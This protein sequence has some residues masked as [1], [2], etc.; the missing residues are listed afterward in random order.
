M[1][2]ERRR[3]TQ[4]GPMVRDPAIALPGI[5]IPAAL[6][7]GALLKHLDGVDCRPRDLALYD[8]VEAPATYSLD[9]EVQALSDFAD[10]SG[11]ER[12]HLLGH[13]AGAAVAL[14]FTAVYPGRVV[15]LAL[16][17]P[18]SDFSP[19]DRDYLETA[20]PFMALPARDRVVDYLLGVAVPASSASSQPQVPE[21]LGRRPAA[22]EAFAKALMGH[23]VGEDDWQRF[24]GPV[25]YTYGSLSPPRWELMANRLR[26]RF[27]DFT[28]ERYEWSHHLNTSHQREPAR[29]AARLREFWA[30]A[31]AGIT[32]S[33][34][35][36]AR[37]PV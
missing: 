12:F 28:A 11:L 21:W 14:A 37:P 13:S 9:T 16:D 27:R 4:R 17:E 32:Y 31:E 18:A 30:A 24:G 10:D 36:T 3:H 2:A 23:S 7:Y 34:S 35:F 22:M 5:L 26:R 8:R 19:E 6:R 1:G 29:V 20:G 15:S 25:Y 33:R